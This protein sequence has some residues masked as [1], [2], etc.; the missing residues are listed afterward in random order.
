MYIHYYSTDGVFILH[1]YK[2]SV[3]R[4]GSSPLCWL[5]SYID[6]RWKLH[7]LNNNV[8]CII[9]LN[10]KYIPFTSNTWH[11]YEI[12]L[13]I[14]RPQFFTFSPVFFFLIF[15]NDLFSRIDWL[16]LVPSQSNSNKKHAYLWLMLVEP[17][18]RIIVEWHFSACSKCCKYYTQVSDRNTLQ[19]RTTVSQDVQT[20][21]SVQLAFVKFLS[22]IKGNFWGSAV[23]MIL[24]LY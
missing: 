4:E 8:H 18:S 23:S 9:M 2:H 11:N 13:F 21:F 19:T 5:N 16:C 7:L 6:A 22:K 3:N 10:N 20:W 24:A 15:L 14:A 12:L 17:W 1:P